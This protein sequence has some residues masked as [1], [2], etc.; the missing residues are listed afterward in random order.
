[1]QSRPLFPKHNQ[2]ASETILEP[3]IDM[4]AQGFWRTLLKY[5]VDESSNISES[6]GMHIISK[7]QE[8]D[9]QGFDFLELISKAFKQDPTTE[10]YLKAL[11]ELTRKGLEQKAWLN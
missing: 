10:D 11:A 5:S 9:F 8:K 4:F 1:M 6:F 3:A 7:E 2:N